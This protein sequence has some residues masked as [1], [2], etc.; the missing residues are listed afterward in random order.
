MYPRCAVYPDDYQRKVCCERA[1]VPENSKCFDQ[2][3]NLPQ[4]LFLECNDNYK[5][6]FRQNGT[7]TSYIASSQ[8]ACRDLAKYDVFSVWEYFFLCVGSM[9]GMAALYLFSKFIFSCWICYRLLCCPCYNKN[10]TRKWKKKLGESANQEQPQQLQKMKKKAA[11]TKTGKKDKS[12]KHDDPLATMVEAQ[13][14]P[15]N[16]SSTTSGMH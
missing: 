10:G 15:G 1:F 8:T 7:I 13:G 14:E 5:A 6:K 16:Q 3:C 4:Q 2:I 9:V 11:K 12:K